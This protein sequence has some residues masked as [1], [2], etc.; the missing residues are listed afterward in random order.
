[1]GED[2]RRSR[3]VPGESGFYRMSPD[4]RRKMRC[5]LKNISVTGACIVSR[6]RLAAGEVISLY[7]E[8]GAGRALKSRVVWEIAG[9]YGVEFL[10][11]SNEEFETISRIINNRRIR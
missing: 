6:G 8:S 11:D 5:S 7:L 9:E 4:A 10:L 1:M 2:R 3:R